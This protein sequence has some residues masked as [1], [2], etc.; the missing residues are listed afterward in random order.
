MPYHVLRLRRELLA[1]V[2]ATASLPFR[3]LVQRY[4]EQEIYPGD[5]QIHICIYIYMHIWKLVIRGYQA[6]VSFVLKLASKDLK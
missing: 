6:E 3:F 1:E 4:F 2:A 5:L